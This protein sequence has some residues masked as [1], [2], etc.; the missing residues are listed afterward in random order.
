MARYYFQL[1]DGHGGINDPEPCDLP[2]DEAALAYARG[3]A[4]DVMKNRERETRHWRIG[5]RRERE[6]DCFIELQFAATDGTLD[7]LAGSLRQLVENSSSKRLSLEEAIYAAGRTVRR[8]RALVSRSRGKPY[9][10]SDE[11][12]R[13]LTL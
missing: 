6:A 9:L 7:H 3:V 5:I 11:W 12:G 8:S 10:V 1:R 4:T 2:D 13:D